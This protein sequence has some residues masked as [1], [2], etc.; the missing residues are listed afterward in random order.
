MESFLQINLFIHIIG[1][2]IALGIA[3]IALSLSK[4]SKAHKVFGWV[5]FGGMTAIFITSCVLS[6]AKNIPFLFMIGVFSYYAVLSGIR[7]I[8]HKNIHSKGKIGKLDWS[9]AVISG[10]FNL[11]FII[12]GVINLPNTL[13]ILAILFGAGGMTM[14]AGNVVFFLNGSKD[15][16]YWYYTH[17]GHMV[18]GFIATVTAFSVQTMH[19]MPDLLQWLWP[20]LLGVPAMQIWERIKRS[21]SKITL[22]KAPVSNS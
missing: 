5:F 18:G 2:V 8:Q 3:P 6:V 10:L 4:W 13:G 22:Q 14:V 12:Y 1:G 16:K 11:A 19:F 9:L 17:A 7:S 20:T 21:K 15:K